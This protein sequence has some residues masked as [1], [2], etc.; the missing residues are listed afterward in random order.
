MADTMIRNEIPVYSEKY[1]VDIEVTEKLQK[2]GWLVLRFWGREIQNN[3][4]YCVDIIE[5]ALEDRNG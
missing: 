1:G 4:E 3:V 2:E 5:K